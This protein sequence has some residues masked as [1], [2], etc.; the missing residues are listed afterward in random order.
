MSLV[1]A[2]ALYEPPAVYAKVTHGPSTAIDSSSAFLK[3]ETRIHSQE[4]RL[5]LCATEKRQSNKALLKL[6]A[7]GSLPASSH[8]SGP[9]V[10]A[11]NQEAKHTWAPVYRARQ[12]SHVC[13]RGIRMMCQGAQT[14]HNMLHCGLG[15]Q[16]WARWLRGSIKKLRCLDAK[17]FESGAKRR[18]ELCLHRSDN[19]LL[20]SCRG[21]VH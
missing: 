4:H 15:S 18:L 16:G 13:S 7:T 17:A 1:G 3:L 19:I 8:L 11:T 14:R 6:I 10:A 9:I 2:R 12:H 21:S 5:D 20:R